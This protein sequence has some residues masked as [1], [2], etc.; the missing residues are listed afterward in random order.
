MNDAANT[1]GL[2]RPGAHW[3]NWVG[4]QAFTP[5]Y[6]A[7]PR[8]EEDVLTILRF[9]RENRLAVRAQGAKHSWTAIVATSGVLVD[10]DAFN[11]I[12]SIDRTAHQ[13]TV[14]PGMRIKAM[15]AV[16]RENGM[17]LANQGDID[18]QAIAGAVMTATHGAGRRLACMSTQVAGMRIATAQGGILDLS[19]RSEPEIFRAAR[20][21][22]G[23]FGLILSL[24]I[25]AVPAY[26]ILK[27]S[28]NMDVE[29]CI[30]QLP[31]LL[32]RHRTCYHQW[33]PRI[34]SAQLFGLPLEG[35]D[36]TATRSHDICHMRSYDAFAESEPAPP[37]GRGEAFGHSAEIFPNDYEPNYHELEY[38]VPFDRALEAFAAVR[39]RILSHHQA[40]FFPVECRAVAADDSY[41]SPYAGRDG[42]A[43]SVSQS[44][45]SDYW[46]FL[47]DMDEVLARYEGRPHWAKLHFM[48]PARLDSLFP[49][50]GEFKELRRRLDPEG[51]F[52][53]DMLRP[54]FA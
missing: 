53:N 27:R 17:S 3:R 37:L 49:L 33:L 39:E 36:S 50:Y 32:A 6:V 7:Q 51:V 11:E 42:F 18:S 5:A 47:R 31:G 25:Q 15:T 41:L 1:E 16:L 52:L 54:L 35:I 46:T 30:V 21:S 9:A 45:A 29:D 26:N 2:I 8:S 13:I 20:V 48:T 22:L 28:W 12:V 10:F 43:I 14:R 24:T 44:P 23:M 38:A 19:A 4:N 40:A 34:E